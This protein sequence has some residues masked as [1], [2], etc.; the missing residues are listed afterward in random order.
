MIGEIINDIVY[1]DF[2]NDDSLSQKQKINLRIKEINSS[3]YKLER[4][5]K[6]TIKLKN[7]FELT[8]SELYKDTH[9]KL[10]KIDQRLLKLQNLVK[11]VIA[12]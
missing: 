9:I 7:E 12:K 3:L 10:A 8:N 5:L 11:S 2:K 6:Q 1:K 4:S